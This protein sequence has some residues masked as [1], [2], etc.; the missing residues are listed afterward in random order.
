MQLTAI[1]KS[2]DSSSVSQVT[3]AISAFT[4]ASKP[5]AN[6]RLFLYNLVYL[7]I[8]SF[9]SLS[10]PNLHN[11]RGIDGH[12]VAGQ[13]LHLLLPELVCAGRS[14]LLQEGR[15]SLQEDG[16]MCSHAKRQLTKTLGHL[17]ENLLIYYLKEGISLSREQLA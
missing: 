4:N 14:D 3:W 1:L 15:R 13:L 2:K 9:V 7:Y 10:S 12:D 8:P 6:E 5:H 16:L 11:R 17:L